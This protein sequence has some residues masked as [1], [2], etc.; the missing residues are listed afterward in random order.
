[1]S[2]ISQGFVTMSERKRQCSTHSK[3]AHLRYWL[4]ALLTTIDQFGPSV[5]N[6]AV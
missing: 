6:E 5:I 2:S 4:R 3:S 1:M